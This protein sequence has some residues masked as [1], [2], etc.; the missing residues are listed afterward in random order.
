MTTLIENSVAA[1]N[2][3]AAEKESRPRMKPDGTLETHEEVFRRQLASTR[4][5]I[6]ACGKWTFERWLGCVE[7]AGLKAPVP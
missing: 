7:R 6:D 5:L 4:R 2:A 1:H 3:W